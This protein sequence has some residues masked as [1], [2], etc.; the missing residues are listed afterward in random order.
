MGT[1]TDFASSLRLRLFQ[2]RCKTLLLVIRIYRGGQRYPAWINRKHYVG[3]APLPELLDIL[4]HTFANSIQ[5]S[6]R[7]LIAQLYMYDGRD[8]PAPFRR[9]DLE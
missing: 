9:V 8:R 1:R 6:E 4:E 7:Y 3:I 2:R 5:L